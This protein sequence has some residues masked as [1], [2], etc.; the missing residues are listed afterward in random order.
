MELL[1]EPMDYQE[2]VHKIPYELDS[3][4]GIKP[5]IIATFGG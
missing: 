1:Y 5:Q 2:D 4:G 3:Q